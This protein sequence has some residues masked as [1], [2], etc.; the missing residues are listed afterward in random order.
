MVG[1]GLRGPF[2]WVRAEEGWKDFLQPM[3]FNA[4]VIFFKVKDP[5]PVVT[6]QRLRRDLFIDLSVDL[7]VQKILAPFISILR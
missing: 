6:D 1:V 7:D 4:G 3:R 5:N 2:Y